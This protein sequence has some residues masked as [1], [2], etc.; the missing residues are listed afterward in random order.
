[1]G[2]TPNVQIMLIQGRSFPPEPMKHSVSEKTCYKKSRKNFSSSFVKISD[3]LFLVIDRFPGCKSPII[4]SY[5]PHSCSIFLLILQLLRLFFRCSYALTLHLLPPTQKLHFLRQIDKTICVP[6]KMTNFS[7][8]GNYE[9]FCFIPPMG[10][11]LLCLYKS[12]VIYAYIT[13]N[14]NFVKITLKLWTLH[15]CSE[16][17][18]R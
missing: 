10:W 9:D 14:R 13:R 1:M 4:P 5:F 6:P 18:N 11:T 12:C 3:Y 15:A 8:N 17:K 16:G 2:S 7:L